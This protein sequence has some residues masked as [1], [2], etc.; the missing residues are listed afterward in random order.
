MDF[1]KIRNRQKFDFSFL[2]KMLD[3]YADLCF[4]TVEKNFVDFYPCRVG[5]LH[6]DSVEYIWEES[7]IFSKSTIRKTEIFI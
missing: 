5:F 6:L 3:F 1:P 2:L 4:T 7:G